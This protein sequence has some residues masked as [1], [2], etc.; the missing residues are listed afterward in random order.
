MQEIADVYT[1]IAMKNQLISVLYKYPEYTLV[2]FNKQEYK[3]VKLSMVSCV[4]LALLDKPSEIKFKQ[5]INKQI[6]NIT[7]INII[8]I[9]I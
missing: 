3:F 5:Y 1:K 9:P 4:I 2:F 6:S 7:G 8:K